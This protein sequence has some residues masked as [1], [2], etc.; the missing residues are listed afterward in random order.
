MN[1]LFVALFTGALLLGG[2]LAMATTNSATRVHGWHS[3]IY[4][5][6]SPSMAQSA[7]DTTVIALAD[8][9][10]LD[11]LSKASIF[12]VG[13]AGVDSCNVGLDYSV[14]N[15]DFTE[16]F[17]LAN[18]GTNLT[19]AAGTKAVVL[20]PTAYLRVRYLNPDATTGVGTFWIVIPTK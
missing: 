14:D 16:A 3:V 7:L 17:S 11:G 10:Y 5:I 2:S 20:D 9:V 6:T 12:F 15:S 18:T 8:E 19:T 1:K 13:A 4:K